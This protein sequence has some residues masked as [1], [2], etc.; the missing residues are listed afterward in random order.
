M[1]RCN[2]E[3]GFRKCPTCE[4]T[5]YIRFR[6]GRPISV[7]F[8]DWVFESHPVNRKPWNKEYSTDSW[9]KECRRCDGGWVFCR[10]CNFN[11]ERVPRRRQSE[12]PVLKLQYVAVNTATYYK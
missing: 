7:S 11:G 4:G 12:I 9:A 1:A 3:N 5:G 10:R 2:C 6:D 8:D